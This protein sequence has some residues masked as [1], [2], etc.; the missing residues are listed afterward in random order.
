MDLG[1]VGHPT[2]SYV[3]EGAA[4]NRDLSLM[5]T[6]E[7]SDTKMLKYTMNCRFAIYIPVTTPFA[8]RSFSTGLEVT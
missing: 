1:E 6:P 5:G 8:L 3:T 7:L 4:S 2:Y